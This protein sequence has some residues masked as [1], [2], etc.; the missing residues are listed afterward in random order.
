MDHG[1]PLQA[2]R[3][4]LS[5]TSTPSPPRQAHAQQGQQHEGT[6]RS[7]Q[8]LVPG[9]FPMGSSIG[10]EVT[11]VILKPNEVPVVEGER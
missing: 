6:L 8:E 2:V 3:S 7:H 10:I 5:T 4:G 11:Q 9:C 1:H